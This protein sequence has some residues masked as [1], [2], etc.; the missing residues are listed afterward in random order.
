M[1]GN[2]SRH[3]WR[4]RF[5]SD[6]QPKL[7]QEGLHVPHER[8]SKET[9]ALHHVVVSLIEEREAVGRNR[10][11][12]GDCNDG[13]MKEIRHQSMREEIAHAMIALEWNRRNGAGFE[14]E[15]Q[16]MVSRDA[17]IGH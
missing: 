9:L 14:K 11:W 6:D 12:T 3:P 2:C 16:A 1:W 7:S 17:P 15:N 5:R 4:R 10:K 13:E 8:L